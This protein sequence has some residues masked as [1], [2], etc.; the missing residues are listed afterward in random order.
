MTGTTKRIQSIDILRGLV[1]VIMALDHTR[2]FFHH[3]AMTADPLDPSTTNTA[4][5]FTRWI[6]HFCAPV[7]VFL[8]GLSAYLSAHKPVAQ[9]S[10]FLL[11]RGIWLI[12]VEI[13]IVSLGLTFNPFYNFIILQVIWAIGCSMLL[14]AVFIRISYKLVLITGLILVFGHDLLNFADLPQ[15]GAQAILL[16]VF[17]TAFGTVLPLGSN[18]FLGV[19]YAILPW[20]GI[21]FV[22]Y[23]CGTWYKKGSDQM[24][25]K[26]YLIY[27]GVLLIVLF[28]V[29]R[30]TNIYGD[31]SLRKDY[32]TLVQDL[33]SFLN[34]SKYPPSLL[35]SCMTIGPALLLL[36]FSEKVENKFA[37]VFST[38]GSVPFFYYIIHFY[39]LHLLLL[40]MFF[41]SGYPGSEIAANPP[42]LFRPVSFGF[43]LP[44][45]YLIWLFVV[46][47]LYKPCLWFKQYKTKHDQWWLKFI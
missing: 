43:S 1:M 37:A 34:V 9:A 17:F 6:T 12:I 32:P 21:M 22:G 28:A 30:T 40:V 15:T 16:K 11:K 41:L 3:T 36:A 27:T 23:A 45:V 44:V 35:Y 33:F 14:L 25:R 46:I 29:L 26:Q 20:T 19:F 4:L 18:H 31:P 10:S 38:Y 5:F 47:S 7:F 39:L 13:V 42:F 2:D 24:K 8:S